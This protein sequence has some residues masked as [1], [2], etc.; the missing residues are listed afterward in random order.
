VGDRGSHARIR[1]STMLQMG[2]ARK[3]A[4]FM[5]LKIDTPSE[6]FIDITGSSDSSD[7]ETRAPTNTLKSAEKFNF[8]WRKDSVLD[9]ENRQYKENCLC[10]SSSKRKHVF[11]MVAGGRKSKN[12]YKDNDVNDDRIPYISCKDIE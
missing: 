6:R 2:S 4:P 5:Q 3:E 7:E 1:C 8:D 11:E 12:D 10:T 9:H